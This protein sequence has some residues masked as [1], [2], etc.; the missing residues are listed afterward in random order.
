MFLLQTFLPFLSRNAIP[1]KFFFLL[2]EKREM[3][4]R[5]SPFITFL[6]YIVQLTYKRA[7]SRKLDVSVEFFLS[8]DAMC[9]LADFR[10]EGLFDGQK[11]C[12]IFSRC[13]LW[14]R[15]VSILYHLMD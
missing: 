6:N 15:A 8:E 9:R 13:W 3:E 4:G 14:V 10:D 12:P 5:G 11:A 2:F 7:L 1:F